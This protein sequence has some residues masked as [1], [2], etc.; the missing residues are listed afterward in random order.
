MAVAQ[1][2]VSNDLFLYLS[3]VSPSPRVPLLPELTFF[4]TPFFTPNGHIDIH[5][6]SE[7]LN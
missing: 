7:Y 4:N 1:H 2:F 6:I 5:L 3:G